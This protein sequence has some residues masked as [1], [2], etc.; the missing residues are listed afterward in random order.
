ME[1]RNGKLLR[2]D[3]LKLPI[4]INGDGTHNDIIEYQPLELR[5]CPDGNSEIYRVDPT[6]VV[7]TP[8]GE[9]MNGYQKVEVNDDS[10]SKEFYIATFD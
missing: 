8:V 4:S 3:G 7:I 9:P 5:L 10:G 2:P 1:Q 6:K